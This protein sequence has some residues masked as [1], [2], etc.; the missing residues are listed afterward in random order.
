M[1]NFT[2]VYCRCITTAILMGGRT[3]FSALT[4]FLQVYHYCHFDGRQDS[5][6]CSNGTVFNQK[7][8]LLSTTNHIQTIK[9]Y[10]ISEHFYIC[11]TYLVIFTNFGVCL[12]QLT[13]EVGL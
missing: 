1:E 11:N 8:Q 9:S 7:V 12:I 6:L 2:P 4:V 13:A 5:F 3:V 10:F